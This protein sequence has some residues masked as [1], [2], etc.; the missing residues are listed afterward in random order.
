V[1]ASEAVDVWLRDTIATL[2]GLG[3]AVRRDEPDS[4]HQ[5]RTTTRRLRAVLKLVPGDAAAAL[6]KE[7]K[8][9]ARLLGDA[10]DLEV[11]AELAARLIDELGDDGDTD[12]A[13]ERLVATPRADYRDAHARIVAYLDGADYAHLLELLDGVADDADDLDVLAVEHETRKHA[14][15]VR[16]LAEALG[17]AET[18]A[19]GAR[20]QDAFGDRRDLELL[21]RSLDGESD[22][23]LL[24]VREAARKH[25]G[26][27]V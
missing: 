12:A 19:E 18:A 5:A 22:D 26:P 7:L 17:D 3:A 15:A 4:V 1:N 16:Y 21:A 20:L 11:R 10:R 2:L 14:R 24:R 6:R 9:Y 23:V 27:E 8:R 25:A 13:H